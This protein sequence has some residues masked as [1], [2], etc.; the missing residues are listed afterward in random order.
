MTSEN[1][2]LSLRNLTKR[3]GEHT[4]L[5]NI[6]FTI[7]QGEIVVVIGPSGTGKST[8]LRCINLLERPDTGQLTLGK[9][10]IANLAHASKSQTLALRRHTA[11]VFQNYALFANK[12]AQ[13]N[14]AE[15]LI[16]VNKMPKEKAYAQSRQLLERV[17]LSDK[18]NS[19]PSQLS[20]GQQQRIGIAR[21]M[22]A[23]A[24]LILFD[25]PTSSLDPEWVDEVL[26]VIKDIAQSHQTMLIVTHEMRFAREI[27][28]RIIFMEGGNII[29]EGTPEHIFS[30]PTD[31][32]TAAFLE[33]VR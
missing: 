26:N 14:I 9:L 5:N 17:G 11:F 25:E 7:K 21:A 4:V 33:R 28:D 12:T 3:Y 29:E 31:P 2:A 10:S 18:A 16:V 6:D 22:A 23:N 32:R 20:G 27:A 30:H 15:R 13:Q 8:L 1:N 19:Y 24:E